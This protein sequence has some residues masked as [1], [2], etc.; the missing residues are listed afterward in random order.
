MQYSSGFK[1][2]MVKRLIGPN[3]VSALALSREVGVAQPTLSRWLKDA[4]SLVPV[5]EANPNK[6]SAGNNSRER[7]VEAKLRLIEGA[8]GLSGEALGAYLRREGITS[9]ELE[10]WRRIV[11]TAFTE[12]ARRP[13]RRS[14]EQKRIRE[15]ERE[16]H[17]K[18]KA[19]AE[20]AALLALKKRA[21]EIW[22]DEDESTDTRS[23]S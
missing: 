9:G 19:L 8:E 5:T 1:T 13:G 2:A 15:L 20:V 3:A 12:E 16:L 23:G 18:E 14:P 6:S 11:R 7:T 22:G 17:R 4:R 21:Q 10:K